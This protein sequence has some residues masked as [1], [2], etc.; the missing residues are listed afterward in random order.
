MGAPTSALAAARRMCER[1]DWTL[2]NLELQKILYLAQM[3]Y[4]GKNGGERLFNGRFEAWDYGPVVPAVY[5][6]VKGFG[7]GSIRNVFFG[8]GSVGSE[9]RAELLDDAYD[10]LSKMT[11]SRLVSITHWKEGAWAKNYVPGVRGIV[12]PDLDIIDEFRKRNR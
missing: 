2:T 3:V 6:Q 1:S 8:I 5:S 11:A 12:I 9:D 10:A 7:G 4:M